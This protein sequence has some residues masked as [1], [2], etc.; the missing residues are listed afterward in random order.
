MTL[1]IG[2]SLV[3]HVGV[4]FGDVRTAVVREVETD[5]HDGNAGKRDCWNQ[6]LT[7]QETGLLP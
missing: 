7:D 2:S 3:L 5:L 4:V 1:H 6:P